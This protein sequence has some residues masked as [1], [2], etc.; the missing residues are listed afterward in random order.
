M[1]RRIKMSLETLQELSQALVNF[2]NIFTQIVVGGNG[3]PLSFDNQKIMRDYI[4]KHGNVTPA[5][6]YCITG[7]L[8]STLIMY[9]DSFEK[10]VDLKGKTSTLTRDLFMT[11]SKEDFEMRV[12]ADTMRKYFKVLEELKF[13]DYNPQPSII[14]IKPN[15]ENIFK[16]YEEEKTIFLERRKERVETSK[17]KV[18]KTKQRYRSFNEEQKKIISLRH[19]K[20]TEEEKLQKMEGIAKVYDHTIEDIFLINTLLETYG[21]LYKY[22]LLTLADYNT[23]R[24]IWGGRDFVF[25]AHKKETIKNSKAEFFKVRYWKWVR[26]YNLRL[27]QIIRIAIKNTSSPSTYREFETPNREE[28]KDKEETEI[29]KYKDNSSNRLRMFA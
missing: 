25:D 13:I 21:F 3:N 4:Q 18:N 5:A 11:K 24:K 20:G 29:T 19:F 15:V 22:G 14:L 16:A 7:V 17:T 23:V 6:A 1:K 9:R 10:Y 26:D 8:F 27:G 28:L 2:I 12:N